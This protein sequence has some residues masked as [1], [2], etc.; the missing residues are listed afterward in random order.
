MLKGIT[1][2]LY[3]GGAV[4]FVVG[5]VLYGVDVTGALNSRATNVSSGVVIPTVAPIET[6]A[7]EASAECINTYGSNNATCINIR[8]SGEK[9]AFDSAIIQVPADQP[10]TITFD[11]VSVMQSHSFVIVRGGDDIAALI[12]EL[13]ADVG[14]LHGYIPESEHI[15]AYIALVAP[16]SQSI[17]EI[18]S[19][20][21]GYY[22]YLCTFPG[23]FG[24]GMKGML[25]VE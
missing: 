6:R 24:E 23:H 18:P 8:V 10:I 13:A 20:A 5:I 3:I 14:E 11:N 19:L 4:L 17:I 7:V 15:M 21:A 1:H 16:Q 22:T 25:L 12:D 9:V 2:Q